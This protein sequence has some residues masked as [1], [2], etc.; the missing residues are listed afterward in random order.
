MFDSI[1]GLNSNDAK[2]INLDK[3]QLSK[4]KSI[5]YNVAMPNISF[6]YND[7]NNVLSFS[8][9]IFFERKK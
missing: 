3:Y 1:S 8:N 2:A 6:T 4:D 5:L 9:E 7:E